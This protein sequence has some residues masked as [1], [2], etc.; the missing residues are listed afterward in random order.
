M[1]TTGAAA[2]ES[3]TALRDSILDWAANASQIK[4][5]FKARCL[6]LCYHAPLLHGGAYCESLQTA[7]ICMMPQPLA[8]CQ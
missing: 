2:Q 8:G 5:G 4:Q 6:A 1:H 3:T 7:S